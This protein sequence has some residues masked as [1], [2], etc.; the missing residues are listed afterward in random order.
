MPI[1]K[2][3]IQSV[4]HAYFVH[5][6][7]GAMAIVLVLGSVL[8]FMLS[9]LNEVPG[10]WRERELIQPGDASV[11]ERAERIENAITTQLT[12]LRDPEDPRWF[13]KV[14]DEQANAWL[15]VRLRDT[16]ETHLGHDAW[17]DGLERVYVHIEDDQMKIGARVRHQTGSAI[18]SAR[19]RLEL[20][21]RGD[22]WAHIDSMR[23]GRTPIPGWA[24]RLL[25]EGDV[26]LGRVRLGPGTLEL[27][28]GRESRLV[29]IRVRESW[30]EVALET[31]PESN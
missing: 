5:I 14:S 11:I 13:S 1:R 12:A 26:Q 4:A 6:A 10:W 20:D 7:L 2:R 21:E 31:T 16:I 18:V 28:D 27:G 29:A 3:T 19:V 23:V 25:G 30:L 17:R 9:G 15:S 24:V 22:L 8:I